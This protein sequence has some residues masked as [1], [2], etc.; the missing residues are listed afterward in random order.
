MKVVSGFS[1]WDEILVGCSLC[2]SNI[3]QN[4]LGK[5]GILWYNDRFN[6]S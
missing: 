3:R 4:T 1:L 5:E 6:I 2:L